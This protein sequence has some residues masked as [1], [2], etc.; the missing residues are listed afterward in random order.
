MIVI[1]YVIIWSKEEVFTLPNKLMIVNLI[2][3][4]PV[5][6][7]F[8]VDKDKLEAELDGYFDNLLPDKMNA[9]R[10]T[11]RLLSN[12][13]NVFQ[14]WEGHKQFYR[15]LSYFALKLFSLV[16]STASVERSFKAQSIIHTKLR[17]RLKHQVCQKL[18][19]IRINSNPVPEEE[20]EANPEDKL[21]DNG[22]VFLS[23]DEENV[24]CR[25][26]VEG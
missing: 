21:D 24:T 22:E 19:K 7:H 13:I 6:P 3:Q 11:R 23:E 1:N 16:P 25:L 18:L 12:E 8:N 2:C 15:Y 20:K 4:H 17:N 14:W 26:N 5:D 9:N 10:K